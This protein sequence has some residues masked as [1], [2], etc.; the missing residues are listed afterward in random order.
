MEGTERKQT[1]EIVTEMVMKNLEK[2]VEPW[3]QPWFK[4][5]KRNLI[6]NEEP[7]STI[8][9]ILL[10]ASAKEDMFFVTEKDATKL[11][12][13]K[14]PEA[15]PAVITFWKHRRIDV[16]ASDAHKYSGVKQ[17]EKGGYY[18]VVPVL[19]HYSVMG[20]SEV[21][22][23]AGK[24]KK[25]V[26]SF[27]PDTSSLRDDIDRYI[28]HIISRTG[29]SVN[30]KAEEPMYV[31]ETNTIHQPPRDA[32]PDA[33]SYYESYLNSLVMYTRKKLVT[34]SRNA[35]IDDFDEMTAELGSLILCAE[36]GL[37]CISS[38][39]KY[40]GMWINHLKSN[41]NVFVWIRS[42]AGKAV[43]ELDAL[44]S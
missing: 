20:V 41:A 2:G 29:I 15:S 17:D 38:G 33:E 27:A 35:N 13:T 32:F 14:K 12:A 28:D 21:D 9:S 1:S 42:W 22:D 30:L 10:A 7:Y 37:N 25:A 26:E 16:P 3:R 4:P 6:R 24:V 8:N 43:K 39:S 36:F 19:K 5:G 18:R 11:G 34:R 40:I 23:P 44:A 31:Q